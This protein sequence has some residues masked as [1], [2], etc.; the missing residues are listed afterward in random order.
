[1]VTPDS[2]Q[3]RV[4]TNP[5]YWQTLFSWSPKSLQTVTAVMKLHLAAAV[6]FNDEVFGDYLVYDQKKY[7]VCDP[8]YI[9]APVGRT[10]PNMNNQEAQIII[11]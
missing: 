6:E 1:M 4:I 10:M 3:Q 11:L 9:G 7:I 8:T 2:L 5:Q